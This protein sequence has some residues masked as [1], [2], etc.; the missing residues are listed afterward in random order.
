MNAQVRTLSGNGVGQAINGKAVVMGLIITLAITAI[1]NLLGLG[2]GLVAL[3]YD[4]SGT[5][6]GVV[7]FAWILV[8]S[9]LATFFGAWIS[10][11]FSEPGESA[12]T[13]GIVHGIG[14]WAAT[15]LATF[16]IA[17]TAVGTLVSGTGTVVKN[18]VN[19]TSGQTSMNLTAQIDAQT[20][21]QIKNTITDRL[22]QIQVKPEQIQQISN[23]AKNFL[24]AT[25]EEQKN[26]LRSK[27]ADSIA[28]NS[29]IN[30]DEANQLMDEWAQTYQ[31]LY[32]ATKQ[33]IQEAAE[34]AS[35]AG[36][37]T[38]L[39]LFFVS[40]VSLFTAIGGGILGINRRIKA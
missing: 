34:S 13:T 17:S 33:K 5:H 35:K 6:L 39:A 31:D 21:N 30:S 8:S 4:A 32:H 40:L 23:S 28:Q 36:G 15:S 11:Y 18:V 20:F 22:K 27:L 29:S 1:L 10:A 9:A 12:R 7:G 26:I 37:G 19:A 24:T 14:I 2:S 16:I 38:L 25:S 3:G